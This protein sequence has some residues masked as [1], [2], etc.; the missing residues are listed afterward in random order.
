M[1]YILIKINLLPF[2]NTAQMI[3]NYEENR[4][5]RFRSNLLIFIT[6][7]NYCLIT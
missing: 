5:E 1:S 6:T 4:Q 7:N 3:G 2:F